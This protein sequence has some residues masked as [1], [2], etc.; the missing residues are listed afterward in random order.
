METHNIISTPDITGNIGS[1]TTQSVDIVTRSGFSKEVGY[2]VVTNSCTGDT[3]REPYTEFGG[4]L[5]ILILLTAFTVG[6]IF[7]SLIRG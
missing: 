4:G 3:Q 6:M 5:M 1:C 2:H 7:N